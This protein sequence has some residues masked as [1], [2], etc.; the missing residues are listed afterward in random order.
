MPLLKKWTDR[1]ATW[2]IWQVTESF[3]ELA[4]SF[5]DAGAWRAEMMA[6]G[7]PVRRM[8][9]TAVRVLLRELTGS[10]LIISHH[11]SGK[12]YVEGASFLISVSHTKGYVAIGI[13]PTREPGI[14][15]EQY[16]ERVNR[17]ASRFMHP[18]ELSACEGADHST[19]LYMLLLHWS[20]KETLYK[21]IG[22]EEVDFSEHLRIHPFRLQQSGTFA[23][24]EYR[25]EH[26]QRFTVHYLTHPDFVCTWALK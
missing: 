24:E 14:D 17:V 1:G 20:A 23:A 3:D 4:D 2:G 7:S 6:L 12:P 9:R 5:C 13:H 16:G 15:I 18:T 19:R 21:I 8:E 11:P 10:E 26:P 25:T 22:C